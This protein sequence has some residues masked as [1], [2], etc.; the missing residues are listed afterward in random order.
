MRNSSPLVSVNIPTFNSGKTIGLTLKSLLEQTY[1]NIEVLIM[2]S[3]ST[4]NTIKIAKKYGVKI[5]FTK[6][7]LLKAREIGLRKSLG[8]YIL[9]LDS[10]QILAK[11]T[12]ERAVKLFDYYDMLFLEEQSYNAYSWLQIL[13]SVDRKLLHELKL[14]NPV[15]GVLLPRFFKKDLLSLVFSNIPVNRLSDVVVYDHAMIYSIASQITNKMGFIDSAVYH[16]EVESVL[17][18]IKKYYRYG[19]TATRLANVQGPS[20]LFMGKT[21]IH[22]QPRPL[23][24]KKP[25]YT[26]A[27]NLL[28]LLK[29][30]PYVIGAWIG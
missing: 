29:G 27:S 28:L 26:I 25:H 15:Y 24:F 3:Y 13:F 21:R 19:R 12:I 4:D 11:D 7:G 10:D 14:N 30:I 5:F 2:D 18:L 22:L 8:D 9:L 17:K 23:Y 1:V 6:R 20:T 16:S